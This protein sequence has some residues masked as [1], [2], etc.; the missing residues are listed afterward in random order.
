VHFW[1][2]ICR[3]IS[4]IAAKE[5]WW[6]IQWLIN[7]VPL[8][9]T[10]FSPRLPPQQIK[11]C[12]RTKQSNNTWQLHSIERG[13]DP[14]AGVFFY[15]SVPFHFRH[16]SRS[17]IP[18]HIFNDQRRNKDHSMPSGLVEMDIKSICLICCRTWR[19]AVQ[20]QCNVLYCAQFFLYWQID[21]LS[22][23]LKF[24]ERR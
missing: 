12:L 19:Q 16:L 3:P 15:T 1:S 10:T 20:T 13:L 4:E 5:F 14:L 18:M 24:S 6:N 22:S 11:F 7:S 21:V 8:I 17:E 23:D 2:L 9:G